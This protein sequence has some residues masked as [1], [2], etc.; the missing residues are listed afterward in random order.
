M[1]SSG[2]PTSAT[3]P[4]ARTTTRSLSRIV[5]MRCATVRIVASRKA[6]WVRS[7]VWIRASVA[8]SMFAVAS[9]MATMLRRSVAARARQRSCRSPTDQF[10]PPSATAASRLAALSPRLA[11]ATTF[12]RSSSACSPKGSTL[13]RSDPLK[14]IGACGMH[15]SARRRR[16]S[17]TVAVST[18]S[19][20]RTPSSSWSRD[21]AERSELLPA[22]V[23]PQTPSFAPA[24]TASVTPDRT[25]G[26]SA[27]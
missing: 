26:W 2:G 10:S 15:E 18:P 16:C 21:S 4:L 25:R 14:R 22:P 27:R 8:W 19:K 7:M 17:G 3:A 6:P 24:G 12:R 20:D 1:R 5:R 13:K 9:S 11:S 23:R